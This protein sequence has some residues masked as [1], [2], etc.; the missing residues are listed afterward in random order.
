MKK[1][2]MIRDWKISK[3]SNERYLVYNDKLKESKLVHTQEEAKKERERL[4][5]II[6]LKIELIALEKK[7]DG[8][9]E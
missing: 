5:R 7:G 8:G 3:S 4:N 6:N 9:S 2:K 1:Q